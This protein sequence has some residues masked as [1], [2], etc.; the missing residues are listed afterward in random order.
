MLRTARFPMMMLLGAAL[1]FCCLAPASGY[2]LGIDLGSQ[3]FKVAVVAPGKPFEIV[4][5]QHS[6]RKTPTAVSFTEK[7]RTFGDDAVASAARGAHKTPM[8]FPLLLGRNYTGKE[9]TDLSYLPERFYPYQLVVNESGSLGYDIGED[10]Y[11]VEEIT[12][13]LIRFAKALS[14]DAAE[15]TAVTETI[16]TVP[17]TA[18]FA[19]RRALLAAARIAGAPRPQLVHETSAAAL[20]RSLDLDLSGVNGTKNSST[21]L[22]YNMGARHVEACVVKF[23]GATH[24]SKPTVAMDVLGCDVNEELGGHHVDMTIAQKMLKA[25]QAKNPKLADGIEKSVRALKKLEKEATG[26]KHVL[27]A[28]KEGLFRVESLFEDTDFAQQVKREDLEEWCSEILSAVDK[29]I[30]KALE[31]ANLTM[32]DLDEVE[33]IGGAW[34]IPKIQSVL[35]DHLKAMRPAGAPPLNLSQHVNGDEAMATGA[36]FYGANSSVSFRTKRIFFTDASQHSYTLELSPLNASQNPEENWGKTVELFPAGSKLRARK[37]VKVTVGFDVKAS[38]FEDGNPVMHW[39]LPGLHEAAT[40][41]YAAL[42]TPLLSLKLDLDS[43]GIVQL[44][45]AMAVFDENVTIGEAPA[46]TPTNTT[47]G[48]NE[49]DANGTASEEEAASGDASEGGEGDV[50]ASPDSNETANATDSGNATSAGKPVKTKLKKRKVTLTPIEMFEGVSPRPLS[51]E[52]M[53]IAADKLTVLEEFDAEIRRV[54]AAKNALEAYIYESRDKVNDDEHCQTVSTEEQRSEISEALMAMEDWLYE[55]EAIHANVSLLNDKLRSLQDLVV[56][57]RRRAWELEQREL[58]PEIIE[59]VKE[60]VN[61]TLTYV[62]NNMTWVDAKELE[63]VKNLT[64]QFEAW[65]ANVTEQQ[66]EKPLTEEPAYGVGQVKSLLH[67]MQT[68]AQRLTKIKKIDP[69]PYGSDYGKYGGYGGYDDPRMR[70]YY[71]DMMRNF[72][73]NGTNYSNWF[74]RNGSNFSGFNDS[75]YM[76]SFYEHAA[77]NFTD[78]NPE[79]GSAGPE[80]DETGKSEL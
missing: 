19:Q 35:A 43:S 79:N 6:K 77:K 46:A 27:S 39:A 25:F 54:D 37:G 16:I 12:A 53:K 51:L 68:E 9:S 55:D 76:R 78:E 67:K 56:P 17:S 20:Q 24:M 57:I 59:K 61:S 18:T 8:F 15:S 26:L 41:K 5:N 30:A 42:P 69:M 45:S 60:Y 80:A 13:H 1:L 29:P 22:F 23:A 31:L 11:T 75:D 14:H 49:T 48:S 33:M 66:K 73:R 2:L 50:E 71:E 65:Y 7:V 63:G 4:H 34:R 38:L 47:E 70:K 64:T 52:E 40:G 28:N 62:E 21:V 10:R 3:F 32:A 36:A 74:N 44:S 58:L 72:S